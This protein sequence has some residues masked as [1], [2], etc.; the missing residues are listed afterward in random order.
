L[1]ADPKFRSTGL[2]ETTPALTAATAVQWAAFSGLFID[3]DAVIRLNRSTAF[4]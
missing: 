1:P 4:V 2:A 3:L